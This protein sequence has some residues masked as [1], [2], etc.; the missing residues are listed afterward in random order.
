MTLN[1]HWGYNKHDQHWK[2]TEDLVR[3]LADIA[4]KGGNFLL[5]VGPTSEGLIPATSVERLAGMGKWLKVNGEAIYGTSGGPVSKLA[6]GRT[7]QK[8]VADGKTRIYLHVFA[9]PKDGKLV[10]PGLKSKV[11]SAG[12]LADASA[13]LATT[14]QNGGVVVNPVPAAAPDAID[15]VVVLDSRREVGRGGKVTELPRKARS[16][17]LRLTASVHLI[18]DQEGESFIFKKLMS[19]VG[20]LG[21][22]WS[23]M[24]MA[25]DD[26]AQGFVSPPDSARPR[27]YWWWL[28]SHVTKAGITRDLEEMKAKGIRGALAL[29]PA[30]KQARCQQARRSWGP[31]G[32]SCS[33]TPSRKPTAWGSR[34]A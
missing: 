20:L 33:S 13:A 21:L 24:A 25:A 11:L 22:L 6:W 5:N 23:G 9:W 26:L 8:A 17:A 30:A 4:S 14:A 15:A 3:K 2:S 31:S 34:S 28:N 16:P 1:D 18:V 10:V 27:V 12:L 7:T 19:L 32:A 29:T